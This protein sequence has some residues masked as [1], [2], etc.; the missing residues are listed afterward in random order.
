[1]AEQEVIHVAAPDEEAPDWFKSW[2]RGTNY[3]LLKLYRSITNSLTIRNMSAIVI[4]KQV[5]DNSIIR[6]THNLNREH[7]FIS[8]GDGRLAFYKI[9]SISANYVDIK[10]RLL[11]TSTINTSSRLERSFDVLDSSIFNVGDVVKINGAERIITGIV[12]S[13]LT[14]NDEV[15][16][17]E[18]RV[19]SLV[20]ETVS[21]LIM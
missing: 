4:R 19:V 16:L 20:R 2:A 10:P 1:M 7:D 14:L 13:K 5:A 6:L 9:V 3:K 21:F 15:N 18:L 8:V 11:S 17:R 12:G